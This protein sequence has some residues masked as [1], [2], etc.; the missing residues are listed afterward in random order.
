MA[1]ASPCHRESTALHCDYY[2]TMQKTATPLN[3]RCTRAEKFRV[4]TRDVAR[5]SMARKTQIEF[6]MQI[7]RAKNEIAKIAIK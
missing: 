5:E 7:A 6:E 4:Q 3:E 2:S 1:L